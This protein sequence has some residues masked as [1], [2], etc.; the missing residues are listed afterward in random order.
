MVQEKKEDE[1]HQLQARPWTRP[2]PAASVSPLSSQPLK[3]VPSAAWEGQPGLGQSWLGEHTEE[4]MRVRQGR[5]RERGKVKAGSSGQKGKD[6]K[7]G[8]VLWDQGRGTVHRPQRLDGDKRHS[9]YPF[10]N[11]TT[12][13]TALTPWQKDTG[14][15][16]IA[17]FVLFNG[18]GNGTPL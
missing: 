1:G 16:I 2:G 18:E 3:A 13:S 6:Q 10:K 11:R 12:I 7:L 4:S 8:E 15:Q 17:A 9:G 5:G 14:S